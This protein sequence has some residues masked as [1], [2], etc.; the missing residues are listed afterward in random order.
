[1]NW[2]TKGITIVTLIVTSVTRADAGKPATSCAA[3]AQIALPD[4]VVTSTTVVGAQSA[5]PAYCKVLGTVRPETD[6]EL[7]LP[8][9]WQGRLLHLGGSGLDGSIP[10][11]D[12]NNVQLQQGYALVGSNG[13][14]AIRPAGPRDS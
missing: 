11:L 3:L 14:T 10:N 1:M 8:A 6:I 4:A 7:R 2:F 5:I 12:L 9:A 13:A